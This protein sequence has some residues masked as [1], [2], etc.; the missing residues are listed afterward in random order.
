MSQRERA[1]FRRPREGDLE[2]EL[3]GDFREYEE[4]RNSQASAA[5]ET[6][7]KQGKKPAQKKAMFT[8][9]DLVFI[10]LGILAGLVY[11]SCKAAR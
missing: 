11:Q 5:P 8:R 1:A 3:R 6:P 10:V 4:W 2:K 9:W 7:S